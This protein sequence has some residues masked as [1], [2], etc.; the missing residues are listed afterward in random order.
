MEVNIEIE[1]IK[2]ANEIK[3]LPINEKNDIISFTEN[4]EWGIALDLLCN[5]IYEYNISITNDLFSRI[6]NI[7]K[8]ME[9]DSSTWEFLRTLIK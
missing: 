9:M 7:A 8:K 5:Q 4:S 3:A 6:I 1:I 2:M